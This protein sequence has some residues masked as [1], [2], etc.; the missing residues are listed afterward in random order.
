MPGETV[1]LIRIDLTQQNS[2]HANKHCRHQGR[3]ICEVAGRR[4]EAQGPAPIYKL[5]T[6][7]WL[8]GHRGEEFEVWDDLSPFGNPGGLAMRGRVRNWASLDTPKG[9]PMYPSPRDPL[10]GAPTRQDPRIDRVGTSFQL[11]PP[12][13]TRARV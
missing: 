4:F 3:A 2:N 9:M 5:V 10:Q 7:L 13:T 11:S 6:L 8:H 12:S 1:A